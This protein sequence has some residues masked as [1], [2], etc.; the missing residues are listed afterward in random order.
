MWV[1]WAVLNNS[2]TFSK[3]KIILPLIE[4]EPDVGQG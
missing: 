4:N 1:K 3:F 2:I